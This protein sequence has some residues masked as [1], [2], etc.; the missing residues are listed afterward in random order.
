MNAKVEDIMARSVITTVKH[1]TVG[2]V[3][4][5]MQSHK[6][7]CIPVVNPEGE[8]AG[9]VTT[10]DL[11]NDLK[12]ST[13][14]SQVMSRKVLAIP[15]YK[16]VHIAARMMRN[17]HVHHLVVT[18]EKKIIGV[19]SSF[20]LLQLVEDHRFVAKNGPASSSKTQA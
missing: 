1:K 19:L 13:P 12:D 2:H 17:H 7:Q 10:S 20:D 5:L 9:I 18:H 14:V 15:S 11:V 8:V 3:R 4:S 6:I 16:G